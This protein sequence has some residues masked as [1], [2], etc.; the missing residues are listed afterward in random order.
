MRQCRTWRRSVG[1]DHRVGYP[2]RPIDPHELP[3]ATVRGRRAIDDRPGSGYRQ[4]RPY[5]RVVY[6]EGVTAHFQSVWIES[7]CQQLSPTN[8]EQVSVR[9]ILGLRVRVEQSLSVR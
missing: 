3:L 2:A 8:K 1:I 7:L 4:H 5:G 6:R 9:G